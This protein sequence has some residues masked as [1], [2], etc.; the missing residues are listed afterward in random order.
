MPYDIR[1]PIE[2]PSKAAMREIKEIAAML[3]AKYN[4]RKEKTNA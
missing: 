2:R 4:K 3:Q 1:Q